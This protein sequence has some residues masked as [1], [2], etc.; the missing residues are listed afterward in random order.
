MEK[1][2]SKWQG[3]DED[4]GVI[5]GNCCGY[6]EDAVVETSSGWFNCKVCV[7]CH[8]QTERIR[9]NTDEVNKHLRN[10]ELNNLKKPEE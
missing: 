9:M 7:D 3:F 1:Q 8:N 5:C 6:M 10:K 2:E 4:E